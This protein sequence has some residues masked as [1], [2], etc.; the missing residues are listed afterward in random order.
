MNNN[1]WTNHFAGRKVKIVKRDRLKKRCQMPVKD[2]SH[3]YMRTIKV[4]IVLVIVGMFYFADCWFGHK[5]HPEVSWLE[6]GVYCPG[7]IGFFAT[8]CFAVCGICYSLKKDN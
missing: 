6:S 4:A 7:P 5:A 3:L 2:L 8:V 1:F